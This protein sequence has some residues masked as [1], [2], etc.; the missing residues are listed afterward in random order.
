MTL[1]L[2]GLSG[3]IRQHSTNAAILRTLG[4]K[5]GNMAS[6]T[7]FPLDD[8]PLYNADLEGNCCRSRCVR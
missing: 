1:R 5:L 7:M 6:L 2:L 4:E 8:V 3:S